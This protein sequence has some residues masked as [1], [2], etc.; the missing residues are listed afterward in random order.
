MIQWLIIGVLTGAVITLWNRVSELEKS[1][2]SLSPRSETP[3]S[4]NIN[5]VAGDEAAKAV[6]RHV[7][8]YHRGQ[9]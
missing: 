4:V 5:N 9:R 7:Q 6:D 8:N 2:R 3:G 1:V